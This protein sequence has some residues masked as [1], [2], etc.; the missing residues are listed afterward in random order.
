M[1]GSAQSF[2]D[3]DYSDGN[4]PPPPEPARHTVSI[5]QKPR[6]PICGVHLADWDPGPNCF[7]HSPRVG[8]WYASEASQT[9][10]KGF[11][12]AQRKAIK[13]ARRCLK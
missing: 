11:S 13:E 10:G 6:C 8:A 4:E 3:I 1:R 7:N 12:E 5:H 9:L 2:I